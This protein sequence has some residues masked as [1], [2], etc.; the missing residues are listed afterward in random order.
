MRPGTPFAGRG[1]GAPSF[2]CLPEPDIADA[3]YTPHLRRG[4]AL[5]E[6]SF[7]RPAPVAPTSRAFQ[8]IQAW[9]DG[10][11]RE[12][13]EQKQHAIEEARTELEAAGEEDHRQRIIGG[14]VIGLIY[15]DLARTLRRVPVPVDLDSEPQ[16]REMFDALVR[17]QARPFLETARTSYRACTFHAQHP[18]S[19]HHYSTFCRTRLDHLPDTET[20]RSG[21]TR[22]EVVGD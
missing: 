21:E 17:S 16:I 11:L 2:S 20:V 19:M 8:D 5:A 13:L 7:D 10:P 15:E 22:V 14:A 18:D 6:A 4:L 12:W 1:R 3:A 9:T